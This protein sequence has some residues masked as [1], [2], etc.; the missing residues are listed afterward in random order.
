M[1]GKVLICDPVDN[2]LIEKLK[3]KFNVEYQPEINRDK[4]LSIINDYNVVVV[5]SRTKIDRDIIDR[6]KNLKIIA[7]AGIG[8]DNIDTDYAEAKNIKI[9]YAPG[10]STESVVEITLAMMVM[11]ARDLVKGIENTRKNDFTKL[12]GFELAGKTL[13]ILGYGRIGHA[14]ADAARAFNMNFIAYD[15]YPVE[16]QDFVK[17]V[18]LEDLLKNSDVLSI[19]VTMRKDSPYILN[20][21][22][23]SMLKKGVIIV[24]TSRANAINGRDM[25]KYLRDGTIKSF[26]SDV[27]WHEPAREDYEFEMLKMPNVLITPHLGAQSAEAQ[28]RIAIMTAENILKE[29]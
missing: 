24:N 3:S 5:R 11:G 1:E 10:S 21:P 12:K 25:L 9:V 19:N 13:G 22:E 27:F 26:V 6:G 7:R 14:I 28:K 29:W 2:V 15:P 20:D 4:L 23:L 8:V 18:T 17:K 16:Y